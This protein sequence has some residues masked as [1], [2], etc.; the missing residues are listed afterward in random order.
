MKRILKQFGIGLMIIGAVSLSSCKKEGCTD[1]DATNFDSE[2]DEDDGS[3]KFEGKVVTW[4]K[5]NVSTAAQAADV[6]TIRIY[7][8][9]SLVKE[10]PANTYFSSAPSCE[11]SSAYPFTIDLGSNKSKSISY[12]GQIVYANGNVYDQW[13]GTT[14]VNGN[15]CLQL[16]FPL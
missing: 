4:W 11:T 13:K 10:R 12:V 5:Q 9:G 15:T 3:C 8:D 6:N 1:G 16:E 2:A 7:I 14:T